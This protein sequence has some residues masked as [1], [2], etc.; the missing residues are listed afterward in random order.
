MFFYKDRMNI[1]YYKT[2]I[3]NVRHVRK[4]SFS[5]VDLSIFYIIVIAIVII[6]THKLFVCLAFKI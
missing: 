1:K 5:V 3:F 4:E 2:N 6:S